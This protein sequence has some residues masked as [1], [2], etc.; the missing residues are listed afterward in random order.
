MESSESITL[1]SSQVPGTQW[2]DTVPTGTGNRYWRMVDPGHRGERERDGKALCTL[3]PML[4]CKLTC[5]G[6]RRNLR[7]IFTR[8]C[9]ARPHGGFASNFYRYPIRQLSRERLQHLALGSLGYACKLSHIRS[10][11]SLPVF[12]LGIGSSLRDSASTFEISTNTRSHAPSLRQAYPRSL[13]E[14]L[15]CFICWLVGWLVG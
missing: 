7:Q 10:R 14:G 15:T 3:V 12:G 11:Q 5:L 4:Y 1:L 2:V 13:T 8:H 6:A 9:G